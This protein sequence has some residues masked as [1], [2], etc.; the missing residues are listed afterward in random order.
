M[1]A[2]TISDS[3]TIALVAP[4]LDILGGQGVQAKDLADALAGEGFEVLFIPINPRFPP[5]MGWLRRIP[6]LRTLV[7]QLLYLPALR[8][9]RRADV[10]HV[11]SASY[12][13]FLLSP[14]PAILASR[15]FNKRVVL[16]YHSG[17]AQDHLG[18][19]GVLVHPWL[20]MVDKIVVPSTYL[21][22][23]FAGFGYQTRV[24][25]NIVDTSL[26]QYRDRS[27]LQPR[28]LSSRNLEP[29]Y[30]V[31]NTLRAF[32]LVQR[33]RP[34]AT[35]T[36]V[37]YGSEEEQLRQWVRANRVAN[38][39]FAGRVE[40]EQM[41]AIYDEADIFINSSVVDNQPVSILEAFAAGLSVISTPT[42]DIPSMVKR[43]LTGEIVPQDAPE[44]MAEAILKLLENQSQAAAMRNRARTEVE[45]YTW[46]SVSSEW[47]EL[48]SRG[49]V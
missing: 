37:G 23:V 11:F 41:P 48:Y 31:D 43:G 40:P 14:V 9:L 13:S 46:P 4:S 7:N 34:D 28:L 17:E 3:Q 5:G 8:E 29:Y 27:P 24:I 19:W 22:K 42:G 1:S 38:V 2:V 33:K 32:A 16:N 18:K 36:V 20:R 10:V 44:V 30:R 25:R 26:F 47:A 12:W 15:L 39:R 6:F 49:G 35:L 21:A 45:K